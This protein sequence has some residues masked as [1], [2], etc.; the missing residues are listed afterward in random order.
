MVEGSPSVLSFSKKQSSWE[1]K[2]HEYISTV[3]LE[4]SWVTSVFPISCHFWFGYPVATHKTSADDISKKDHLEDSGAEADAH[5]HTGV[6][7]E[8]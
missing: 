3:V 5:I 2:S 4:R 7:M 8:R 1:S 6:E